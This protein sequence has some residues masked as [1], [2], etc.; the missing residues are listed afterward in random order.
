[1]GK[2]SVATSETQTAKSTYENIPSD[3]YLSLGGK[4]INLKSNNDLQTRPIK[5]S[6]VGIGYR[7]SENWGIELNYLN[8]QLMQEGALDNASSGYRAFDLSALYYLGAS[9]Y[10]GFHLKAGIEQLNFVNSTFADTSMQDTDQ[11]LTFGAG[12]NFSINE[13]LF[14]S[15]GAKIQ[16]RSNAD[17]HDQQVFFSL[18]YLWDKSSANASLNPIN[19]T[20]ELKAP[21][22]KAVLPKKAIPS[23]KATP[24]KKTDSDKDGITDDIDQ[25]PNTP[26]QYMVD[27]KGCQILVINNQ[28]VTLEVYFELNST[29]IPPQYFEEIGGIA[30]FLN[31]YKNLNLKI[32]GH[33]D[34]IG[35]SQYNLLLSQKR[36][37][38][39]VNRLVEQHKISLTRLTSVGYG[40]TKPIAPN[41]TENG[42]AKNRRVQATITYT[43]K[44][45]SLKNH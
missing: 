42:R 19:T 30:R 12:Y 29:N 25:C 36:A 32:E 40:E 31:Q 7:L 16:K 33:T 17:N 26:L 1:M 23:K 15:I 20:Q 14:T 28:S 27:S 5:E 44:S 34:N 24:P 10:Q 13:N 11:A 35:N 2:T 39:V 41:H 6:F 4:N 43:T 8:G 38:A 18:N 21:P 3:F 37:Q 45:P 9:P 22:F